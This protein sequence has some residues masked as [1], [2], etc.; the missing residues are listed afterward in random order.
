MIN[1]QVA[2]SYEELERIIDDNTGELQIYVS[3]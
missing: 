1:Q 2:H 3:H